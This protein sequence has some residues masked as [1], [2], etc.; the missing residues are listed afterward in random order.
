[1][2]CERGFAGTFFGGEAF[3]IWHPGYPGNKHV[4]TFLGCPIT[5][6]FDTGWIDPI[7][8]GENIHYQSLRLDESEEHFQFALRALERAA[9]DARG[10][11]IPSIGAF[12]S[13][14]D[15]L[16]AM[17]GS[18]ELLYDLADRPGQVRDADLC[19]TDIW[20]KVYD[21][22]YEIIKD[23]AEGSTCWFGLWSP[24]KF[25]ALQ[26]D[27]SYMISPRMFSRIFLPTIEKQTEFLDHA[28]YHVDG[29]GAFVHVDA[30]CELPRLQAIQILPGAGKPSPLHYIDVLKKV[31]AAG[32]N[33]HISIGADEVA[34]ALEMLSARGLFISTACGSEDEARALLKNAEKWSRD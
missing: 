22:F 30:L 7:L 20:C 15:T 31:Q 11:S 4:A 10:K 5:L 1:N 8:T 3:P 19:L 34:S 32:R 25:F 29:I 14:G 16:A 26:N 2:Q 13:S 6:D 23:A 28:V 17:R 24:G 21:R 9:E 18:K 27:F 33:L 12:G